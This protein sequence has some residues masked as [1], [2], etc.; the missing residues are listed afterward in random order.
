MPYIGLLPRLSFCAAI[1]LIALSG[2]SPATDLSCMG[3]QARAA[4]ER[5]KALGNAGGSYQERLNQMLAEQRAATQKI[6]PVERL[7]KDIYDATVRDHPVATPDQILAIL[8]QSAEADGRLADLLRAQYLAH[9]TEE[10]M[11]VAVSSIPNPGDERKLAVAANEYVINNKL[12]V[13]IYNAVQN[14]PSFERLVSVVAAS[15]TA[16][17]KP[18]ALAEA[19]LAIAAAPIAGIGFDSKA[20]SVDPVDAAAANAAKLLIDTDA[21]NQRA[22]LALSHLPEYTGNA[23]T[24]RATM[25]NT[26]SSTSREAA[27]EVG[28]SL[29]T[30]MKTNA[31]VRA[32]GNLNMPVSPQKA[33]EQLDQTVRYVHSHVLGG[34]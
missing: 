7:W 25:T 19:P 9:V 34:D 28:K 8:R 12:P 27:S 17:R 24:R 23:A 10:R 15:Q 33:A 22:A 31:T 5:I 13:D 29:N 18:S 1:F 30:L 20:V 14:S 2:Q 11:I 6:E 26:N 4:E 3:V 21:A 32:I 16:A